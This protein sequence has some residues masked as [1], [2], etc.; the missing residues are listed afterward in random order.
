M[1]NAAHWCWFLVLFGSLQLSTRTVAGAQEAR[2][3]PDQ[4]DYLRASDPGCHPSLPTIQSAPPT[5]PLDKQCAIV[6]VAAQKVEKVLRRLE[7]RG[8]RSTLR[9]DSVR[10][11]ETSF[12]DLSNGHVRAFW[13]LEFDVPTQPR[14]FVVTIDKRTGAASEVSVV[15]RG[16]P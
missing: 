15:H 11:E 14:L 2:T 9:A 4:T 16:A 5:L 6:R 3:A 13:V 8:R 10:I 1:L 12:T 7:D